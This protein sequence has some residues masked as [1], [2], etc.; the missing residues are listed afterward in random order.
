VC[1][2]VPVAVVVRLAGLGR[3]Q[4]QVPAMHRQVVAVG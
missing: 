1:Q 4:E 2:V 3:L